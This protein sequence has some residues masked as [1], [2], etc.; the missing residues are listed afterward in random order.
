MKNII[1]KL[2]NKEL[3]KD[4]M[5][6]IVKI[7]YNNQFLKDKYNISNHTIRYLTAFTKGEN[8]LLFSRNNKENIA[9]NDFEKNLVEYLKIERKELVAKLN[10]N[11]ATV[12]CFFYYL[13]G[14][15]GL[16]ID[17]KQNNSVIDKSSTG[18]KK[19]DCSRNVSINPA[20]GNK[21]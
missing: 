19:G 4:I 6:Y 15:T 16:I 11:P 18:E 21:D 5:R 14:K 2:E 1:A 13:A 12:I 20:L 3:K 9:Y 10:S 17:K 8:G 7:G